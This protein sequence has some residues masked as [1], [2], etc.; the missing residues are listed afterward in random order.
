MDKPKLSSAHV[1]TI[2][3]DIIKFVENR[4]IS[5]QDTRSPSL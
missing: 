3:L 1:R 2:S 4:K 5:R